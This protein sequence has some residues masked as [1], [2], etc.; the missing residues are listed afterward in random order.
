MHACT[1]GL[2]RARAVAA[3]RRE[4]NAASMCVR[5]WVELKVHFSSFKNC[6]PSLPVLVG[7]REFVSHL[8]GRKNEGDGTF[9]T[10]LL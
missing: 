3:T 1:F 5:A 4:W 10:W 2:R 6:A 9:F 7:R 8:S